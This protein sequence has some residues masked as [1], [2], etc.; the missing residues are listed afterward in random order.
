[1]ADEGGDISAVGAAG[2]FYA[3]PGIAAPVIA[4]AAIVKGVVDLVGEVLDDDED[5]KKKK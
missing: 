4:G 1:M 5:K 2:L 3:A